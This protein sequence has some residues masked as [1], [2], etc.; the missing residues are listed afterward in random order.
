MPK[1]CLPVTLWDLNNLTNWGAGRKVGI[2]IQWKRMREND[3][4]FASRSLHPLH[5]KAEAEKGSGERCDFS[6]FSAIFCAPY[7]FQFPWFRLGDRSDSTRKLP[8]TWG[9]S[10]VAVDLFRSNSS[11][12]VSVEELEW[13]AV[14]P[15]SFFGRGS[16]LI[17][18][19]WGPCCSACCFRPFSGWFFSLG[20]W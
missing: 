1:R 9:G 14:F 13:I 15:S 12:L 18:I 3:G 8:E 6:S 19:F 17:F 10:R 11:S 20:N 2:R 4:G 16:S 5:M 7:W